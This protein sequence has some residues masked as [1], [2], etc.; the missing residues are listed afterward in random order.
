LARERDSATNRLTA[1]GN[2]GRLA[3]E[4]TAELLGLRAEVSR[5]RED[6]K[7]ADVAVPAADSDADTVKNLLDRVQRLKKQMATIPGVRIPEV[8][9]LTVKDW[10]RIVGDNNLETD[11]DYQKA[12]RDVRNT[13]QN[14]FASIV[15]PALNKYVTTNNGAYP[16]DLSQLQPFFSTPI[17]PAMLARWSVASSW[18]VP[19]IGV[20]HIII[21]QK[22]SADPRYD[23]IYAIG[24]GGYGSTGQ[25]GY[26]PMQTLDPVL[27]S[28]F[29]A[30][31]LLPTDPAQLLPF[32]TTP[33][34]KSVL[35]NVAK[36]Y[37]TMS[38]S[39]KAAAQK[40][41]QQEIQ[42]LMSQSLQSAK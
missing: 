1:Q 42:K 11:A 21:T 28:Y 17:D 27:S 15:Q 34:Q 2:E 18:A 5:L 9:L 8:G 10:V 20:G 32:T 13:A 38:P 6:A 23:S 39:E 12:F 30:N 22:N 41:V 3:T 7:K 26:S 19:N 14:D 29:S 25:G 31:A 35:A 4:Q 33:E 16:T 24:S 40:E 36:D 37:Q